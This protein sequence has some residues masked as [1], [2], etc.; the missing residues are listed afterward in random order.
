MRFKHYSF[1]ALLLYATPIA[2]NGQ[3]MAPATSLVYP[4]IDGKLVYV[5]G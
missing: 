2:S 1:L 5:T 4:G 3:D